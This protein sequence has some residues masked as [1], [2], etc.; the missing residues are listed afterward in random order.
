MTTFE[1]TFQP[2]VKDI[3]VKDDFWTGIQN[4]IIDKAI[5]YQ[6][7][8]LHDEI[9][10]IE[11]SHAIANFKIAAGM[12][13]G[14]FYGMVFQ[15]SDVAKWL[16]GVAY[17]LSVREDK[18][19]EQRADQV[20][21]II[22]AAQEKSGYLDT[23]F[24]V[25]EPEHKW[26]NLQECHELYCAGHMME[27][28]VAYYNE[29]GKD[30]L[31]H[32][33]ERLA[34]HIAEQFGTDKKR[35]VPGHQEVEVG[36]MRLYQAT[37]KE[38]YKDLASYFIEER[39][40]NYNYFQE[41]REQRGWIHQTGTDPQEME[42][43]NRE[44]SQCHAPVREQ[45]QAVGH[46]VRAAYMYRAMAELAHET[47]DQS[48]YDACRRL[49][50][51]I[52]QKRM[53]I[54]G[55]I[56]STVK[57]EAFTIDYDLPNDTVYAETCAAIA[58]VMFAKQ[59]LDMEAD[60]EYAD[61]MER[62]L[63]NGILSGMQLDGEAFFYVNPLEVVQGVSGKLFGYKHVL[64]RR[65]KW[66]ACACCP[67]NVVRLMT[68]VGTYAWTEKED[69]IY[70]HLFMGQS[71]SLQKA[72][73]EV[74]S[75]LPWN[76]EVTYTFASKT[77]KPFTFAIHIPAYARNLKVW[78]NGEEI[79]VS[80]KTEK[81][82]LYLERAWGS[83]DQIQIQFDLKTTRIY[84]NPRVRANAGCVA[85]M[86]GP[87]VYCFETDR[88]EDVLQAYHIPQDGKIEEDWCQEGVLKN[89]MLLKIDAVHLKDQETLY[90]EKRAEKEPAVLTAIPYFAWGNRENGNMRVWMVEDL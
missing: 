5:P 69:A 43:E 7:K 35:G 23:Y 32:V 45:K 25:K 73:I 60:G 33:V 26:Q 76:G 59:M 67:P 13:K 88:A 17:A 11:K 4:L 57:G 41:E 84:S 56:G 64:P 68:S 90:S 48:M 71:A 15:D 18:D 89:M 44:Y 72:E 42:L 40:K 77:E 46:S 81:G 52:V 55:G 50:D 22:E 6:E 9:P 8:V 58:M 61:I 74:K 87:I 38:K 80:G 70:S 62:E 51:N 83:Q 86:R 49:W 10:G 27:A 2:K 63:Y 19:L 1:K 20:I 37:G 85:F 54:T 39:G 30:R 24:I 79:D 65:P 14:E 47:K 36:L 3:H 12:E 21:E 78:L 29:T 16:E 75:A 82:Y 34:D 28:A 53:Y 66:Y 31:L